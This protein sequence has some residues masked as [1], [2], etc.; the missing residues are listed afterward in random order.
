[1]KQLTLSRATTLLA[2][3]ERFR[4]TPVLSSGR[5]ISISVAFALGLTAQVGFLTHQMALLSPTIGIVAAG[6]AVSL[7]T[8]AAVVGRIVVGFMVDQFDRRII[9]GCNFIVQMLGMAVLAIATTPTL[10][11]VQYCG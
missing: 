11:F 6:W 5:F 3:A 2:E 1:V 7:T 4:L 9:S 10:L 8:F